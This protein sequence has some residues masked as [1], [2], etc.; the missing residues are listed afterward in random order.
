MSRQDWRNLWILLKDIAGREK[1]TMLAIVVVSLTQGM[2]PFISIVGMGILVDA[3]YAGAAFERL[4]QYA[5]WMV[6]GISICSIIASRASE[7]MV[8]G[9]ASSLSTRM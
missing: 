3:V 2:A 5:F 9:Q 8:Q 7:S 1:K 4:L 6:A